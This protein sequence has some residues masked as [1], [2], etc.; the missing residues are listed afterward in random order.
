MIGVKWCEQFEKKGCIR[1]EQIIPS[2]KKEK[3]EMENWTPTRYVEKNG[4]ESVGN[5]EIEVSF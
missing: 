3:K 5:G 2:T 4:E 1:L